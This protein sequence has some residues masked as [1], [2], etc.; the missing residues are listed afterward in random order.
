M[1]QNTVARQQRS[2]LDE[3]DRAIIRSLQSDGR[4]PFSRL[5]PL[6][7]LSPAAVRQRVLQ[8]MEDGVMSIVAVT[9][10]TA[11]GHRVQVMLGIKV[12]GDLDRV[13]GDLEAQAEVV[14]LVVT[15]GRFDL[16]AEIVCEDT[17][18]LLEILQGI[19]MQPGVQSAEVFS[20]LRLAKQTYNW[21]VPE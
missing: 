7:D 16:L 12:H 2:R 8:L 11:I 5:G 13:V 18:R 17:T 3:T 15:A 4:M 14:Y 10:P 21:G 20:Y 9:D 1:A 19:R 6:V